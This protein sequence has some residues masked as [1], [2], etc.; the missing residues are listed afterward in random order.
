MAVCM[1]SWIVAD[2]E[3][4]AR[5]YGRKF[6]RDSLPK[7]A[8]AETIDKATIM[9]TLRSATLDTTKGAYSKGTTSFAALGAIDVPVV[10]QRLLF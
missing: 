2:V 10:Q 1:E 8:D 6:K 5:F 3:S 7:A 4:L 9:S